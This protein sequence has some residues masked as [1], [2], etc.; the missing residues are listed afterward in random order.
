MNK[1]L[2]LLVTVLLLMAGRPGNVYSQ[3]SGTSNS[4]L[5]IIQAD[6]LLGGRNFDRLKDDVIM[7][8]QNS[9]IYCDSAYFYGQENLAKLFGRV[10]IVDQEDPVVVTSL[11][12]EYDGNTQL[13]KLRNNVVFKNEETTLYTDFLDYDRSTGEANYFNSGKVVDSTNVLTSEK[14]LYQTQLDKITFTENVVLDNPDYTLKS[15]V[16]YYFTVTKI[17]ETEGITNV[18]SKEGNKLNAKR[19]SFYDTENKL[20]RFYDGDA[21]TE[22]SKVYGE[23]L[24]YDELN[25]YYEAI[26]NVS[27][28]NKEREVEIFGHEGKYW[29][30]KQYSQVYGNALVKRYF[31]QDTLYMI[32]D[33]LI[34]QDS[35]DPENR[36]LL[37]FPNMRMIKS[38]LAGRSDSMV[39]RYADST[40]YLFGDPVMWNNKTQIT[41]DSIHILIAN[42]DIDKT[43]L[44]GNSFAITKDIVTN[45]NQIKGRKMTGYFLDGQMSKLD[46]E[47]NGESLYFA[48][49]NDTTLRG[50][51]KLL[52][53]RIIMHFEDNQV[54]KISH[55][56][57]PEASFTPPHLIKDDQKSLKG[58]VW[59]EEERPT[60]ETINAW[61]TP[62]IREKDPFN[63]FNEPNERLHY[64]END[65][66]QKILHGSPL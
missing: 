35:E 6:R 23:I 33:T 20:F 57:K 25:Q 17:A 36:Y 47:G 27:I 11:Y 34:S 53:G 63:F 60:M 40:I 10:R 43:Y 45:F 44:R 18:E 55:T 28:Y 2:V 64:P 66:I 19:G 42:Q 12:A 56:L 50:I 3:G 31:E 14:G 13:A 8:H 7:K 49:E 32:S 4:R 26:E 48:L 41:A 58:F 29:E 37:A 5:E 21:E 46:V 24:V 1:A 15:N 9:L 65:E 52:C 16:L 61:R 38:E 54:S 30:Q 59:R 22:T 51:N 62:K 39:Y